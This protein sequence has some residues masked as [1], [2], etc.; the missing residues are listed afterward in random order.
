MR[1]S[2]RV[3]GQI[4]PCRGMRKCKGPEEGKRLMCF[5]TWRETGKGRRGILA[6]MVRILE[7]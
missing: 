3:P 5:R 4:F 1:S 7:F 2:L 6:G